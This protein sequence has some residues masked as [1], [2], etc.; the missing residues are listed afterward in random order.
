[1]TAKLITA[2]VIFTY[3]QVKCHYIHITKIVFN[4]DIQIV[5]TNPAIHPNISNV[6]VFILKKCIYMT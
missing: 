4:E 5:G 3:L 2:V 1:M 6:I